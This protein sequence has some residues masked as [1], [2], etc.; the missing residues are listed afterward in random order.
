MINRYFTSPRCLI[1][2]NNNAVNSSV[3]C[4]VVDRYTIYVIKPGVGQKKILYSYMHVLCNCLCMHTRCILYACRVDVKFSLS[5][6]H[7]IVN[8][9]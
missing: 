7:Y 5:S 3:Q 1:N 4:T 2:G 8:L 9:S 6:R